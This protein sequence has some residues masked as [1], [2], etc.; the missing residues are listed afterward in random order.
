MKLKII[1]ITDP[2]NYRWKALVELNYSAL[3]ALGIRDLQDYGPPH[4]GKEMDVE[5]IM[6]RLKDLEKREEQLRELGQIL[7]QFLPEDP[8][9][10]ALREEMPKVREELHAIR[11]SLKAIEAAGRCYQPESQLAKEGGSNG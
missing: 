1:A 9:R 7:S 11:D 8:A 10:A 4:I 3:Y 5:P 6:K 2:T